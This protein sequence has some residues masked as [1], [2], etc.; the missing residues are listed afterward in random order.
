MTKTQGKAAEDAIAHVCACLPIRHPHSPPPTMPWNLEALSQ[1]PAFVWGDGKDVRSLFYQ[2]ERFRGKPTRVFAYY[3]SPGSLS[4]DLSKDRH[5]PAVVLVH[6]GGGTAFPEWVRLWA[7]RGYAA[8][9]MDLGGRGPGGQ[10]VLEDGGPGQ[11]DE[12]KFA[13]GGAPEDQWTYHAVANVIRAHSLI[14]SFK[15]VDAGRTAITGI[16]WGAYLTCIVAGLDTRFKAAVPVYGCGFLQDNS[17][18]REILSKMPPSDRDTWVRLWDPSM[19]VSSATMPMLFVNGG[20]DFAYPPDSHART[21]ALVRSPKNLHFVPALE[22]GHY[23]DKPKAIEV[24]MDRH[25]KG[26]VSLPGIGPVQ[27]GHNQVSAPVQSATRLIAADLHYTRDPLDAARSPERKWERL[28]ASIAQ[29]TIMAAM[30]PADASS[31]FLTV[32]DEWDVLVSSTL[33]FPQKNTYRSKR[34]VTAT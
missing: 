32:T 18:W 3:A 6:G 9:A 4:G 23:F 12:V 17:T 20:T 29:E 7:S 19:Y 10:Q 33:V 2:G 8:I 14:C 30:P 26:G 1:P 15:D 16:S 34:D 11:E 24:F 13:T 21:Y 25:L 22:H 31:W 27:L 28:P 5:L